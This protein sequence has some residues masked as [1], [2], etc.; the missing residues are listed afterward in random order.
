MVSRR[1]SLGNSSETFHPSYKAIAG[2]KRGKTFTPHH[3]VA[4]H[5]VCYRCPATSL[6]SSSVEKKLT[7]AQAAME[8]Q[9]MEANHL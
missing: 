7:Y 5:E 6:D 9:Y 3:S 8:V 2:V 4:F 1:I